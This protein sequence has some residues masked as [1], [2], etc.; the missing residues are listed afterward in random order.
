MS[1]FFPNG[2]PKTVYYY[3]TDGDTWLVINKDGVLQPVY[4]N[5]KIS[6]DIKKTCAVYY[7]DL[8]IHHE[9]LIFYWNGYSC[10]SDTEEEAIEEAENEQERL[11][12]DGIFV[13]IYIRQ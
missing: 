2:L 13:P 3:E 6:V 11:E 9:K 8:V 4:E 1:D 12:K 7:E 10:Y 5:F